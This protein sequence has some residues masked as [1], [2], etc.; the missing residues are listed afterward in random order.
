M[1]T[2]SRNIRARRRRNLLW[3][4]LILLMAALIY[5][6]YWWM[7][8]RDWVIS[9]NAFI[10]GNLI[11]VEADATGIVTQVLAEESQYVN[12]GDLLVRLDGH[13]A[14]TSMS[15]LE[16]ELGQ[17]VREISALFANYQQMCQKLNARSAR[18]ARVSHDV[19][20]FRQ[21][22]P[23][24]S[25]SKQVL[26]NAEDQMMAL[27]AQMLEAKAELKAIYAR[28]GGT[29][30]VRH[31]DIE[32]AKNRFITGYLEYT[33][34][35]I[36]APVSGYVAMRKVQVGN[37]IRPGDALM[38]LVPLEHLWVEANLRETEL[39][40]VRPGQPAE[41]TVDLYGEKYTFHGMVEGL[42]PGTGS[43]FALLPP[44]N[45]T[46]NFIHIVERVPVR[47]ALPKDEV[48]KHPI[49]PGLSTITAIHVKNTKKAP[50]DFLTEVSSQEYATDVF[51]DELTNARFM[52]KKIIEKNVVTPNDSVKTNCGTR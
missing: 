39:Q 18:L 10:T 35:Q 6:G 52:A 45:A 24:G 33:R 12:K 28:I 36:Y 4:S 40:H 34:Q 15:Q 9:H 8:R 31:P 47:I 7:Y 37:R 23:N 22:V 44:D 14:Q 30:R 13:R 38:T 29:S 48:L 26:Q 32:A 17:T 46:G 2:H 43:V 42:V 16:G 20:R 25:V 27:E 1:A 50:G 3:V 49:R 11:P 19:T 41:V 5:V 21:G 51:I